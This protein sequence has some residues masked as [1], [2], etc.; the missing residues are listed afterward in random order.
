MRNLDYAF[1]LVSSTDVIHWHSPVHFSVSC[2]ISIKPIGFEQ[3]QSSWRLFDLW[4]CVVM[5]I[6]MAV[7]VWFERCRFD[8]YGNEVRS[9]GQSSLLSIWKCCVVNILCGVAASRIFTVFK[10]IGTQT[11]KLSEVIMTSLLEKKRRMELW[12]LGEGLQ[13]G[14]VHNLGQIYKNLQQV[15]PQVAA[16]SPWEVVK[17]K[18]SGWWTSFST[19]NRENQG[20]HTGGL[21]VF[22]LLDT[23]V[24][25]LAQSVSPIPSTLFQAI[26]CDQVTV[27]LAPADRLLYE[28]LW[29]AEPANSLTTWCCAYILVLLWG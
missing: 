8:V 7:L 1:N 15:W 25:H 3:P 10:M 5:Y 29:A 6:C 18:A 17:T 11:C 4:K 20:H 13:V 24:E 28:F 14:L 27:L 23:C 2:C 21:S 26:V 19:W 16:N 12:D 9:W 22:D